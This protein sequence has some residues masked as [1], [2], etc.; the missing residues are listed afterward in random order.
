M[1]GRPPT[2]NEILVIAIKLFAVIVLVLANGF[3][4]AAEFALV[5]VRRTRIDELVENGNVMARAVQRAVRDLDRYIAATQLGITMASLALGFLGEPTLGALLE[6]WLGW[7]PGG[8][9]IG[10]VSAF[11][12]ITALH[13]I[14]GELAPK[15]IALQ[16]P[17]KTSLTVAQPLA[18]F[19]IVFRPFIA[20]LNGAG[21]LAVRLLGLQ[22]AAGHEL[23]HSVEELRMLVE[24][25]GRAGA[26]D[27]L[28]RELVGRAFL[29]GD[30]KAHEV[31]LP[32]TE[33]SAIP[34][35]ATG[36]DLLA[37]AEETG[38]SRFPVYEGSL[39]NIVG[40]IH[41]KDALGVVL[42]GD[43][44]RFRVAEEM[45]PAFFVPDTR[46]ADTLLDEMREQGVRMACVVDEFGGLAGI[47]T[48][49]RLLERLVGVVR[50]EFEEPKVAI[51]QQPDG[52]YL[53][54]GLVLIGELNERLD[55]HLDD[56]EYDT[57]GG[58]T[59]G[60]IGRKPEIGESAHTDGV[61]LEVVELD[62]LRVARVRLRRERIGE[63]AA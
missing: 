56:R 16:Y 25:S 45:R 49:E 14:F 50:E 27:A 23:V 5:S 61:R 43:V 34:V 18:V 19:G 24:A 13:I 63:D 53:V 21:R 55:L 59:F 9:T 37:L 46:P 54:D 58:L 51:A 12:I 42:T 32:R 7:A 22:P 41:V 47:V 57:V 35:S 44:D 20:V 2:V 4:V 17:E 60:L 6:S 3:F 1:K 48:F 28:E 36:R 31:M 30:F 39:D 52:S 26:L 8:H 40:I 62:G 29:L 11:V 10:L 38:F 33:V 15:S